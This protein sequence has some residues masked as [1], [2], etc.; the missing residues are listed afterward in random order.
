MGKGI[1]E[2]ITSHSPL[3]HAV[4]W[5]F[6]LWQYG[7]EKTPQTPLLPGQYGEDEESAVSPDM[8][9]Y[10]EGGY[11]PP[12][13]L[14]GDPTVPYS[15]PLM[16]EMTRRFYEQANKKRTPEEQFEIDANKAAIAQK[17]GK[18]L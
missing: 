13:S 6:L 2:Y 17:M 12:E 3:Q 4:W 18:E 8:E 5:E 1:D 10:L 9:E 16:K 7:S 11:L 14:Q 15:S